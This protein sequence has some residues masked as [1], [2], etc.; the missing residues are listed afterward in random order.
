MRISAGVLA[1]LGAMAWSVVG[2]S[3]STFAD[4]DAIKPVSSI[5]AVGATAAPKAPKL[6]KP[7]QGFTPEREAAAL[8]FVRMHHG[9]LADLLD[10]LKTR[11]PQEYQKAIRELFRV[12]ER[13]AMS[14]E[15]QPLRYEL[16]LQEWKLSSRIQLLVARMSMNR[17]PELEQELRQLLAE[18][19]SVHRDLIRFSY[20]RTS[21]RAAA[22]QKELT[23]LEQRQGDLVEERFQKVLKSSGQNQKKQPLKT[24]TAPN[25]ADDKD[26]AK[27]RKP[28]QSAP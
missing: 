8:T 7:A 6:V 20:E 4:D 14:Q 5:P 17:T 11:R 10:R 1:A 18:Q 19:V 3:P 2:H 28:A 23:D 16:E 15:Q 26:G 25:K 13:L 21:A 24:A 12:S 9:E 22:L 27:S